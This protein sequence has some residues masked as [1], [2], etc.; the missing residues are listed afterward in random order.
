MATPAF[1][2]VKRNGQHFTPQALAEFLAER[3][4]D[5]LPHGRPLR[6][7]DPACG[8]GE[9]LLAA[10]SVLSAAGWEV[11]ELVGCEL[12]PEAAA[13]A[14]ARISD[15]T[16][17]KVHVGDFLEL[18]EDAGTYGLFDLVIT[19]PPYVR[20]QVLGAELSGALAARFGLKGRVDL[21]HAFVTLSTRMLNASGALAL[22]C[23]NRFLST[24]AGDNVRRILDSDFSVREIYDLGD[25]KLFKAAVLPAVV[26][27]NKKT[28][29]TG[30]L[31]NARFTRAYESTTRGAE[32][33]VSSV[34][35]SITSDTS[36]VVSVAGKTYAIEVGSLA[37]GA[38]GGPWGLRTE[39]S[40]QWLDEI[41]KGTW[42]TFGEVAKTR[43]GIK[44]TADAVF[45]GDDW[46]DLPP[47][48]R[49]EPEILLPLV[50]HE[51]VR[52]WHISNESETRVLYPYNLG[53]EKREL[54]QMDAF[55]KAMTYL[56]GHEDRLRGRKYVIDGGRQWF[57]IW[58]P[59]RPALW[60]QPKIV[61]PDISEEARFALDVSGSVVNGDCY[62]ISFS[63]L[64]SEDVGFLMLAVGNSKLGLRFYDTVCGNK[65]Y[66]GRR[67]WIT[68]YVDRL[69]LPDPANPA[70]VRTI[71]LARELSETPLGTQAA[72]RL[73]SQIESALE[74]AFSADSGRISSSGQPV[75][76]SKVPSQ[77][78]AQESLF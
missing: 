45:I 70:T 15:I 78:V 28:E 10:N 14:A 13:K 53:K 2:S 29:G 50:T 63:D 59:Q 58:V 19:N 64:P 25:T 62:W 3:A 39:E 26:I 4:A 61:F 74:E 32:R 34:L 8:D 47:E 1:D 73:Q 43:V 72:E 38:S 51:S 5:H 76:N 48:S 68:Q 17:G 77:G 56:L 27:A 11:E 65:L 24:K 40:A 60:K 69:P 49:P 18:A 35:E 30:A 55:P 21:T 42:K 22:L 71:D 67:R 75:P 12:D 31:E 44:T 54:L 33:E 66:S 46:D 23:S 57:E 52:P 37:R 9:L 20:T 41:E 16:Q 7:M 6:I 36:E